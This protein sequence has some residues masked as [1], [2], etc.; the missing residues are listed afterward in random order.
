MKCRRCLFFVFFIQAILLPR[1]ASARHATISSLHTNA[2]SQRLFQNFTTPFYPSTKLHAMVDSRQKKLKNNGTAV[3]MPSLPLLCVF[4]SSNFA[5][6]P[7]IGTPRFNQ[8]FAHKRFSKFHYAIL[9][10]NK[11]PANGWCT[12]LTF[13]R[14]ATTLKRPCFTTSHAILL[15]FYLY[16][17]IL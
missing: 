2:F 17:S 15:L 5:T 8:Q 13:N 12:T 4:C 9:P 1:Q 7:D 10:I 6:T 14:R 16:L 3:K 11:L